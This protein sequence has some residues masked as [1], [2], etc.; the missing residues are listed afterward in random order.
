MKKFKNQL[1]LVR[2]FDGVIVIL[3]LLGSFIPLI[4][5]SQTTKDIGE[6]STIYAVVMID[7]ET[8]KE[9]ELSE[10]TPNETFTFYPADEQ[11]NIIEVDGTK[12]RNKEDN[13]PDQIAVKTGWI[14]KPGETAICLPHKLIIE[15]KVTDSSNAPDDN[16]ILPL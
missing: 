1:E 16:V 2:P 10:N 3:L 13:S 9:I 7:G 14:S 6:N 12:I 8:V 11:Y 5:F 15:V 4:I